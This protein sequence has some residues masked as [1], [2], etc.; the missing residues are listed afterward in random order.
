MHTHTPAMNLLLSYGGR[1]SRQKQCAT[2]GK[3]NMAT[4]GMGTA[5]AMLVGYEYLANFKERT[6]R[7]ASLPAS[8]LVCSAPQPVPWSARDT[9]YVHTRT[10]L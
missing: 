8:L 6:I 1:R 3:S 9:L 5:M 10:D 7:T 4:A 2:I